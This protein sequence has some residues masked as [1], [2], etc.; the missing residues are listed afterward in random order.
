MIEKIRDF[1]IYNT[2]GRI[3]LLVLIIVLFLLI[4]KWLLDIIIC[5]IEWRDGEKLFSKKDNFEKDLLLYLLGLPI[6]ILLWIFRT[7]DSQKII[8]NTQESIKNT[9]E[10]IKNNKENIYQNNLFN[11]FKLLLD[12]RIVARELATSQLINLSKK[13][14]AYNNEIKLAFINLLKTFKAKTD[15]EEEDDLIEKERRTYAQYILNWFNDKPDIKNLDLDGLV[16][17]NQDFTIPEAKKDLFDFL[18]FKDLSNIDENS[19]LISYRGADL[20]GVNLREAYLKS[21]DLRNANLQNT[22]LRKA[23]LISAN[24]RKA[25]LLNKADLR[26]AYLIGA[27]LRGVDLSGAKLSG[28]DLRN[29]DLRYADLSGADLRNADLRHFG[30]KEFDIGFFTNEDGLLKPVSRDEVLRKAD[31]RLAKYNDKTKFPPNFNHTDTGMVKV[32]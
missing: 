5:L 17:D 18:R 3:L 30:F 13:V 6:I 11:S 21:A 9:Q 1:L 31:L 32:E 29:A 12:D 2:I 8:T 14:P 25:H 20:S 16:L 19:L 10:S 15:D 27:N 7:L 26:K 4:S 24:L 28:A 23:H 22:D